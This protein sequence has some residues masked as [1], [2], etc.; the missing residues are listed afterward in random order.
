VNVYLFSKKTVVGVVVVVVKLVVIDANVI[1][2][3]MIS[4]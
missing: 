1:Q 4:L 3:E 2:N